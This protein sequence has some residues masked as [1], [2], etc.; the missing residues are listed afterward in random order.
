MSDNNYLEEV[1]AVGENNRD[2]QGDSSGDDSD[3][4]QRR[5][6]QEFYDAISDPASLR[7]AMDPI[8]EQD[9]AAEVIQ[10]PIPPFNDRETNVST[11]TIPYNSQEQQT[12][13][14]TSV[15]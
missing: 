12:S 10:I 6:R 3:R 11:G 2:H 9:K 13:Q 5:G 1:Y 8:S 14:V 4:D 7:N 15:Q